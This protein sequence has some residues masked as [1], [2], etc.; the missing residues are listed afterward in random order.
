MS[1]GGSSGQVSGT[2]TNSNNIIGSVVGGGTQGGTLIITT[3]SAQSDPTSIFNNDI[4]STA[5]TSTN[6]NSINSNANNN[7]SLNMGNLTKAAVI[8]KSSDTRLNH[9]DGN[10]ATI[11]R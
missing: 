5:T 4:S 1:V 7:Q 2:A 6:A 10:A 11:N 9:S 8:D 3:S